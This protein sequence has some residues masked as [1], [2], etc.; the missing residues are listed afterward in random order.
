MLLSSWDLEERL[1]NIECSPDLKKEIENFINKEHDRCTGKRII[2]R[3][4]YH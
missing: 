3:V 2:T 4:S 1:K